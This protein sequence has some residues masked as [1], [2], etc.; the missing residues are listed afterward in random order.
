M[1]FQR[2]AEDGIAAARQFEWTGEGSCEMIR[3]AA[4]GY[5]ARYQGSIQWIV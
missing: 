2:A 3:V 4:D 1:S 5:S